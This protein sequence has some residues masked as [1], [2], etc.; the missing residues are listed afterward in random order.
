MKRTAALALLVALGA[1]AA[2][3]APKP[4]SEILQTIEA[5]PR[6]LVFSAE[7]GRRWWE[8]VACDGRGPRCRE[9]YVDPVTARVHHAERE[10]VGDPMPPADGK[11]ASAIARTVEDRNLGQLTDLEFDSPVWEAKVRADRGRA[12][13]YLDPRTGDIQRCVGTACPSRRK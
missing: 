13:L 12:K 10:I 3:A 4:L 11:L 9:L 1:T 7:L 8:I 6:T 2:D 5:T